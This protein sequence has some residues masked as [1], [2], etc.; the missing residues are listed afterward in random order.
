[1][2]NDFMILI[3]FFLNVSFPL[4]S[5][6][7]NGHTTDFVVGLVVVIDGPKRS[8]DALRW[9]YFGLNQPLCLYYYL[10]FFLVTLQGWLNLTYYYQYGI[11]DSHIVCCTSLLYLYLSLVVYKFIQPLEILGDLSYIYILRDPELNL[12]GMYK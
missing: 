5:L 1:M 8:F 2:I 4:I 9:S 3:F 7:F 10:Y 12:V 11:Y 6:Q